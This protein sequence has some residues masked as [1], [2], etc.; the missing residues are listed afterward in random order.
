MYFHAYQRESGERKL[1]YKL[2][3]ACSALGA[4]NRT[5][6]QG[7]AIEAVSHTQEQG[8]RDRFH[9]FGGRGAMGTGSPAEKLMIRYWRGSEGHI[10]SEGRE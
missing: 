9:Q 8:W 5:E 2:C 4:R 10:G 3:S 7:T 6:R 1:R